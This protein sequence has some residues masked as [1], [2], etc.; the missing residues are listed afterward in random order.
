VKVKRTRAGGWLQRGLRQRL[1]P[2]TQDEGVED[3]REFDMVLGT[4]LAQEAAHGDN[5]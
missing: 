4:P 5:A 1:A 3:M 2:L